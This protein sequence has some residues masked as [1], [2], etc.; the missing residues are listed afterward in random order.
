MDIFPATNHTT[1]ILQI[2][3]IQGDIK[4]ETML[5]CNDFDFQIQGQNCIN[6]CFAMSLQALHDIHS[7]SCINRFNC[8]SVK[9]V[10]QK[11]EISIMN[12]GDYHP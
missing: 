7:S 10:W 5:K 1:E 9:I 4:I 12:F 3:I 11:Q 8:Q 2:H 6:I